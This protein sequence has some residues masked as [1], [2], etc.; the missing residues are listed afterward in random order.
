MLRFL[1]EKEK[2]ESQR[3]M[4]HMEIVTASDLDPYPG[5]FLKADLE[6]KIYRTSLLLALD[7]LNKGDKVG[8]E[9][10]LKNISIAR[11]SLRK[12]QNSF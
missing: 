12:K 6:D 8:S 2:I 11:N 9:E 10:A 4:P 5:Y 1:F 3:V 7:Y